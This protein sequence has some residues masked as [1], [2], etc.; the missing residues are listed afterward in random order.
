MGVVI[1]KGSGMLRV[2]ILENKVLGAIAD[3]LKFEWECW[4]WTI[5]FK[6]K[7]VYTTVL[8]KAMCID[9]QSGNTYL[10]TDSL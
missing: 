6:I 4:S 1:A 2:T 5:E 9:S 8:Y 10:Y 7:Y 3:G